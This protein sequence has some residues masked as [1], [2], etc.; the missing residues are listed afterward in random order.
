MVWL[1]GSDTEPMG[2]W[3]YDGG[4]GLANPAPNAEPLDRTE[5]MLLLASVDYGRVVFSCNALPAI[6]PVN[7]LVDDG[8]IILRTRLTSAISTVVR[9]TDGVVVAYEA[10]SIDVQ[11]RAGWSVVA[12]GPVH[13]VKDPQQ[14]SRY[15]LLLHPWVNHADTVVAIEPG[16]ITG[17][18]IS[19]RK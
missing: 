2:E 18:R 10:D 9:S 12:T 17:F 13:T 4:L 1:R 3:G 15:E 5:A 6:R 14:I 11:T 7:H 16:V 19:A 8:R